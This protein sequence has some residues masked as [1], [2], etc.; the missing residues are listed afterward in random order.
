MPQPSIIHTVTDAL[1]ALSTPDWGPCH[2]GAGDSAGFHLRSQ[3]AAAA[4]HCCCS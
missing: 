1:R 3:A 4:G 2:G